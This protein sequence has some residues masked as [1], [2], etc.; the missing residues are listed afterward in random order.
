MEKPLIHSFFNGS[1]V[2]GV[3]TGCSRAATETGLAEA[4]PRYRLSLE[5]FEAHSIRSSRG[6]RTRGEPGELRGARGERVAE[7]WTPLVD[8]SAR[9]LLAAFRSVEFASLLSQRKTS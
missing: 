5:A 3:A 7:A 2:P 6:V 8:W 9:K 1:L 4:C